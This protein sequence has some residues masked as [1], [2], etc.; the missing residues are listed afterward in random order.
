MLEYLIDLRYL[1][2]FVKLSFVIDL[3]YTGFHAAHIVKVEVN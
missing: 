3:S 2:N 1:T